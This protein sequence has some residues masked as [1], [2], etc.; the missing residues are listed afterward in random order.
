MAEKTKFRSWIESLTPEQRAAF[1][2]SVEFGDQ[3]MMSEVQNRLPPESRF[4]GLYGLLPY[5]GYDEVGDKAEINRYI[6]RDIAPPELTRRGFSAPNLEGYYL[7]SRGSEEDMLTNTSQFNKLLKFL[8]E[9]AGPGEGIN[10]FYTLEDTPE[11]DEYVRQVRPRTA[12]EKERYADEY[13]NEPTGDSMTISHELSHRGMDHPAMRAF[14]ADKYAERDA[15]LMDTPNYLRRIDIANAYPYLTR[16]TEQ[17]ITDKD[18]VSSERQHRT[19]VQRFA[20]D[21]EE[22]K[23]RYGDQADTLLRLQ[24]EFQNWLTPEKQEKYGVRLPVP[25]AEPVDPTMLDKLMNF[26]QGN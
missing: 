3:E 10:T 19:G 25:A 15:K 20:P 1:D 26:I 22:R 24:N 4:G 5:I 9:E 17:K 12:E 2:A 18:Y 7:N 21:F 8:N 13:G 14:L 11:A 23:K 16:S 6:M